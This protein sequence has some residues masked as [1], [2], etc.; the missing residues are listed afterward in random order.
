MLQ[1]QQNEQHMLQACCVWNVLH[2]LGAPRCA[3]VVRSLC[4][5]ATYGHLWPPVCNAV[6]YGLAN[7]KRTF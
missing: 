4:P 5:M 6:N 2:V 3:F 7:K 1:A